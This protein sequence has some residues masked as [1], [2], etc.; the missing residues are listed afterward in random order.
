MDKLKKEFS[1]Y[2][3]YLEEIIG[4]LNIQ[5]PYSRTNAEFKKGG[6]VCNII[7]QYDYAQLYNN[8]DERIQTHINT[9]KEKNKT[10]QD[11]IKILN[12][13]S[14]QVKDKGKG[15]FK[16]MINEIEKICKEKG[17]ILKVSEINNEDLIKMLV[18]NG[19]HIISNGYDV[20]AIKF[21]LESDDNKI[22]TFSMIRK[23]RRSK[24]KSSVRKNRRSKRKS[25]VKKNRKS[26][27]KSSVKKNRKTI[28]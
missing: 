14:I 27:R 20:K 3:K 6:N 21:F 17:L 16:Y 28:D 12:L 11:M 7:V 25:S 24:R 23:N 22:S 13:Q 2:L 19:Y 10:G 5:T 4:N 1:E 15:H 9:L 18:K 8:F 26:K